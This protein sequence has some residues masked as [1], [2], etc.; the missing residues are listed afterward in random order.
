[1]RVHI[2]LSRYSPI[3][4][5]GVLLTSGC[6]SVLRQS[7]RDTPAVP[8]TVLLPYSGKSLVY[9]SVEPDFDG[10]RLTRDGFVRIGISSFKTDGAVSFDELEAQATSVGADIVLFTKRRPGSRRALQPLAQ[11]SDGTPHA[12]ASYVHVTGSITLFGANYGGASSV[13]GG[14]SDFKGRVTSSGIPGVSAADMAAI[15]APEFEYTATFWRK[16]RPS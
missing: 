8:G 5:L 4:V 9:G 7:Y 3:L 11:N 6:A 16:A 12:L 13:G 15:N 1:M 10:T 2:H 14:M